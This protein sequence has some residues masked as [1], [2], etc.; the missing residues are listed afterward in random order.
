[1]GGARGYAHLGV[2]RALEARG[3]PVDVVGGTSMGALLGA[4]IALDRDS[5]ELTE[6]ALTIAAKRSPLIDFT[7]PFAAAAT[8]GKVTRL[9]QRECG[10]ARIEDLWRP[11]FCMATNLTRAESQVIDRGFAWEAVR[12]S[13]AIPGLFPPFLRDGSDVLVDGGVMNG[14]PADV[15]RERP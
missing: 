15:M 11:Y 7:L 1:G 12:A 8:G 9:L 3:V 14:L 13:I 2:L 10:D 5:A 6:R 4:G